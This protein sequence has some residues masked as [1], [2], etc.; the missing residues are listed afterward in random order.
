MT[1]PNSFL[2]I[3]D[4]FIASNDRRNKTYLKKQGKH[5]FRL[6]SREVMRIEKVVEV[7]L[8]LR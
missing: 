3:I 1:L 6:A 4:Y 8:M 5:I 2:V 7:N